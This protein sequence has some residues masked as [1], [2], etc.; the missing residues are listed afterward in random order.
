MDRRHAVGL[1]L[2]GG[3]IACAVW[4]WLLEPTERSDALAFPGIVLALVGFLVGVVPL[5][6]RFGRRPAARPV[7]ILATLLAE[8]VDGQ[9]LQAARERLLLPE[10][11]PVRWSL[12][13]LAVTGPL[14]AAVGAPDTPPAFPPLP[15]HVRITAADLQAGGGRGELHALYAGLASG[16]LVVTGIP[17]AGKSGAAILLL[18]DALAHRASLDDTER[19][20]VPVPV[21]LTAH[22]WDPN[23]CS[24]RDWL[25]D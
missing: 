25:A 21:L 13:D 16:R 20:R 6:A 15:G 23:T 4:A 24:A 2:M 9:W 10:P 19:V 12:T 18:L 5:L 3:A 14:D 17:G 8:S 1:V 7:G 22:G 11:I